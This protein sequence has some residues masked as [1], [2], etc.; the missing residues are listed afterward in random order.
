MFAPVMRRHARRDNGWPSRTRPIRSIEQSVSNGSTQRRRIRRSS[1][2][3]TRACQHGY[4]PRMS[5]SLSPLLRNH[6]GAVCRPAVPRRQRRPPTGDSGRRAVPS[7]RGSGGCQ[8]RADQSLETLLLL[9][10]QIRSFA[11]QAKARFEMRPDR[12]A[13]STG[14]PLVLGCWSFTWMGDV[15]A[16]AVPSRP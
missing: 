15:P 12:A 9:H 5:A 13:G 2:S 4:V 1:T 3:T 6:I 14:A 16:A 8:K 10:A 11:R 7:P